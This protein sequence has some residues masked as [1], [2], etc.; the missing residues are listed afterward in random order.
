MQKVTITLDDEI[1]SFVNRQAKGNRSSYINALLKEKYHG[2]LEQEMIAALQ[3]D[4]NSLEYQT[5]IA[6]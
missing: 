1:L 4:V 3:E 6:D 2:I 5:E